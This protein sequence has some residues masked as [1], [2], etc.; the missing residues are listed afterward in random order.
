MTIVVTSPPDYATNKPIALNLLKQHLSMLSTETDWDDILNMYMVA[1]VAEFETR[2]KRALLTQTVKQVFD[3]FPCERYFLLERA[4][5]IGSISIQY[6]NE[7][8][9]L[10]TLPTTVYR[11]VPYATAPIIELK[12]DQEWATDIHPDRYD[13]VEV[14]YQC[15]YGTNDSSVPVDIKRLLSSMIGDM[16]VNREDT[17][18]QPGIGSAVVS[19]NSLD[20]MMKHYTGYYEHKSQGRRW[21]K[22]E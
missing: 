5:Y 7:L 22:A 19:R 14:S 16:F 18:V 10:T 6:Y 9:V 21:H 12:T 4:P 11:V 15:G 1:A 20:A 8:D 2:T 3:C 17:V 13:A